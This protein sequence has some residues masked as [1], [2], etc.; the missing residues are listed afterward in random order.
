MQEKLSPSS[1]RLLNRLYGADNPRAAMRIV[2]SDLLTQTLQNSPPIQFAPIF[3]LRGIVPRLWKTKQA[4]ENSLLPD[5][6]LNAINGGFELRFRS[7]PRRP[8][9]VR[10]SIAH[11]IGHTF[12]FDKTFDPPRKRS[13]WK[14]LEQD[15]ERLCDIFASELLMPEEMVRNLF[16]VGKEPSLNL[17][18]DLCRKFQVSYEAM[19]HRLIGDLQIWDAIVMGIS[20]L[21]KMNMLSQENVRTEKW[22]LS[23]SSVPPR[24]SNAL[25]IPSSRN[26][27]SFNQALGERIFAED[28][29]SGKAINYKLKL[30]GLDK[31]V[32]SNEANKSYFLEAIGIKSRQ[33]DRLLIPESV[34]SEIRDETQILVALS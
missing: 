2:A 9:R 29:L 30:G 3:R 32:S 16:Y 23:W 33:K 14:G 7:N 8:G 19:S 11:E 21:P 26:R 6:N 28:R 17:L 13:M 18:V 20:W 34:T 15:E 27:P 12:F 25:Y 22:R 10:F 24:L 5:A 4:I 31:F 1:I